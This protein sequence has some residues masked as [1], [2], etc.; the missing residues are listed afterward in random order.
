M[1][2]PTACAQ[3]RNILVSRDQTNG[4]L[5]CAHVLLR[6][7]VGR[8]I[9]PLLRCAECP[10]GLIRHARAPRGRSPPT[11][12]MRESTHFGM[13]TGARL[14]A[15]EPHSSKSQRT[16]H[17]AS[18]RIPQ[19]RRTEKAG[20]SRQRRRTHFRRQQLRR[21]APGFA[22]PGRRQLAVR[23][24]VRT[25]ACPWRHA[26]NRPVRHRIHAPQVTG[27]RAAACRKTCNA[28]AFPHRSRRRSTASKLAQHL[29]LTATP[30]NVRSS[31]WP[32]AAAAAVPQP[33]R[34]PRS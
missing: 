10:A 19:A 4:A 11:Y 28:L 12:A 22:R 3:R 13:R 32:P 1:G 20:R 7:P 24:C 21:L 34:A 33:P 23:I 14:A 18:T 2:M 15:R 16:H 31:P 8:R 29:P 27:G 5:C 30:T 9:P 17:G 25:C 26:L 6:R